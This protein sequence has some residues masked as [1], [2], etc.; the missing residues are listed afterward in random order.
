MP[1]VF[2]SKIVISG[3]KLTEQTSYKYKKICKQQIAS[4]TNKTL[5]PNAMDRVKKIFAADETKQSGENQQSADSAQTPDPVRDIFEGGLFGNIN[6][7]FVNPPE[8]QKQIES[9]LQ[10]ILRQIEE[11][12]GGEFPE[13]SQFLERSQLMRDEELKGEDFKRL[14]ALD[15]SSPFIS[16]SPSVRRSDATRPK[17]K[18]T[19]DQ[20]VLDRIHGIIDVPTPP[21][22]GMTSQRHVIAPFVPAG[23]PRIDIFAPPGSSGRGMFQ[24]VITTVVR[25]PDGV[26]FVFRKVIRLLAGG[27]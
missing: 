3:N 18:L 22:A 25:R 12:E 21:E 20:K 26:S 10:E 11:A 9:Q 27:D 1:A 23:H 2:T 19:D 8:L 13:E 14:I 5:L 6:Q 17:N 16:T 24:E 7:L 15:K 4:G